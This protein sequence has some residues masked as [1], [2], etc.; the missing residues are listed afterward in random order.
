[1]DHRLRRRGRA[2]R[3]PSPRAVSLVFGCVMALGLTTSGC[4]SPTDSDPKTP[5]ELQDRLESL[6]GVDGVDVRQPQD[7]DRLHAKT[8]TVTMAGDAIESDYVAA[9]EELQRYATSEPELFVARVAHPNSTADDFVGVKF[10]STT[11]SPDSSPDDHVRWLFRGVELWPDALTS[12]ENGQLNVRLGSVDEIA[13]AIRAIATDPE[14]SDVLSSFVGSEHENHHYLL[15]TTV[16]FD[17]EAVAVWDGAVAAVKPLGETSTSVNVNRGGA[18]DDAVWAVQICLDLTADA[19][20]SLAQH[21]RDLLPAVS[22]L[23]DLMALRDGTLGIGACGRNGRAI[24]SMD[25]SGTR[26]SLRGADDWV[27]W[28]AHY[29]SSLGVEVKGR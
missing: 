4:S 11:Q 25:S 20:P 7:D 6:D 10:F 8:V 5:A 22:Q 12:V 18:G 29:V 15:G 27:R 14:I 9:L 28:A 24:V 19:P 16:G 1:M 26:A 23:F 13:P 3:L 17:E 2:A 21:R